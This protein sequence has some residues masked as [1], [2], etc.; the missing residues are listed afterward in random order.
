ME[1]LPS[2]QSALLSR[3]PLG[4]FVLDNGRAA[5]VCLPSNDPQRRPVLAMLDESKSSFEYVFTESDPC[6]VAVQGEYVL[7]L[8]PNSVNPIATMDT[9][10]GASIFMDGAKLCLVVLV[11][12][13]GKIR[14]TTV[15]DLQDWNMRRPHGATVFPA[16]A[17]WRFGVRGADGKPR[18]LLEL[19]AT[20]P[21]D[22][23]VEPLRV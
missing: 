18:W 10:S 5:F 17:R 22:S 23:S 6:V 8:D 20:P 13:V 3:L 15:L 2:M 4:T 19:D 14:E 11:P 9:R 16:V 7:E 21:T 1:I 12:K